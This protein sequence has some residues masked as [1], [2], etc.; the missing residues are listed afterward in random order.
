MSDFFAFRRMVTPHL[1]ELVA[2]VA[3]MICVLWGGWLVLLGL[4][5]ASPQS[6]V[7]YSMLLWGRWLVPAGFGVA[8]GGSLVIR[9]AA[10]ALIVVFR[11]NESLTDIRDALLRS[12]PPFGEQTSVTQETAGA[13]DAYGR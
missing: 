6:S 8:V 11:I 10:E 9:V 3:I 5:I 4:R 1:I 7:D 2:S 13:W 12:A